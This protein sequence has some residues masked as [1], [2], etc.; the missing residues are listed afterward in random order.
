VNTGIRS[1]ALGILGLVSFA[2]AG[3]AET[4]T[5]TGVAS[6]VSTSSTLPLA[7]GGAALH[8]SN[9]IVATVEESES[10]IL[11]GDCAG[12]GYLD[13]EGQYSVRALCTFA[14]SETDGFAIEALLEPAAE[15]KVKV[16]GGSGRWAGAT[17]DGSLKAKTSEAYGGSFEYAFR[18]RTP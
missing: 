14:Q 2:N 15:G 3:A 18:I 17:G 8:L 11:Y 16:I 7:N 1:L 10:G 9:E 5:F 12:L 4:V 13:A 6:F